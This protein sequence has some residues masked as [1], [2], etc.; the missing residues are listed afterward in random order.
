MPRY[1]CVRANVKK[2][3]ECYG[4]GNVFVDQLIKNTDGSGEEYE[5]G[6]TPEQI[7]GL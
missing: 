4:D 5:F 7:D 1:F 6:V 2:I 3:M